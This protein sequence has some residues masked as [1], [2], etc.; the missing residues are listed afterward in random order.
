M[1]IVAE[2]GTGVVGAATYADVS[3]ADAYWLDRAHTDFNTT[4]A[5]A[6]TPNKEG[7][8]REAT[9]YVDATWGQYYLGTRKGYLQGLEW[10]R[11]DAMD[12]SGYPLPDL[13]DALKNVVSELAARALSARL[14]SDDSRG[15]DISKLK[16]GPVEI[17]YA[18]EAPTQTNYGMVSSMLAPVLD[19][20]QPGAAPTSWEWR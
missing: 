7:A 9:D 8:L 5:A 4:W 2:D 19:G 16:A 12:D 1:T 10:P 20:R 15:G 14:A 11:S 3:F 13:P 6:T 18:N 17:T